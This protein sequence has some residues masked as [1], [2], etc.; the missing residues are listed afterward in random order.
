MS[1]LSQRGT[2]LC[3]EHE[4]ECAPDPETLV[5]LGS[6]SRSLYRN[7]L[8]SVACTTSASSTHKLPLSHTN[9]AIIQSLLSAWCCTVLCNM[10]LS[11]LLFSPF[12]S[13]PSAPFSPP[14]FR[15]FQFW[16]S[17]WHWRRTSSESVWT[18]R[19]RLSSSSRGERRRKYGGITQ[20]S[21]QILKA[22]WSQH[23]S[24]KNTIQTMWFYSQKSSHA[25]RKQF[26]FFPPLTANISCLFVLLRQTRN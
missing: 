3:S 21:H 26:F 22:K 2:F 20:Q 25:L 1:T 13:L 15:R 14:P 7:W 6:G 10:L 19:A 17:G 9:T 12:V 5:I 8:D 16:S 11:Y 23:P 24:F 18:T 4:W